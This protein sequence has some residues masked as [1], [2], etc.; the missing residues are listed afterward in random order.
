MNI[1]NVKRVRDAVAA[2]K[3]FDMARWGITTY[4]DVEFKDGHFCGSPGCI[5]GHAVALMI[6]DGLYECSEVEDDHTRY[7]SIDNAHCDAGVWM[8]LDI[9]MA[10]ELFLPAEP[11]ASIYLITQDQAVKCLDHL[12]ETG[13]VDWAQA[14]SL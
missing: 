7:V 3:S 2:S 9:D 4:D 14:L 5:R 12:L 13:V 8:G 10:G 6:D 11:S 1:E